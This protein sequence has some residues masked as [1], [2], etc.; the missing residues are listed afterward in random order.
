MVLS[1][2]TQQTRQESFLAIRLHFSLLVISLGQPGFFIVV[3]SFINVFPP[4]LQSK[5]YIFIFLSKGISPI[6][7]QIEIN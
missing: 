6:S 1:L 2:R 4:C 3:Y 5:L 7:L